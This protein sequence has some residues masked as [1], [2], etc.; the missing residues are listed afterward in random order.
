MIQHQN[1]PVGYQ[2]YPVN[3]LPQAQQFQQQFQQ[4]NQQTQQQQQTQQVQRT[5]LVVQSEDEVNRYPVAP[6]NTVTFIIDGKGRVIEKTLFSQFEEPRIKRF[7]MVEDD[8]P[9]V[10]DEPSPEY[11]LKSDL[12][13][14]EEEIAAIKDAMPKR[15]AKRK[16]TEDE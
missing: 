8:E 13:H 7:R 11:A 12:A 6:G 2:P 5:F 15:P 4:Y 10:V 16:E 3:A 1:F 14:I 9:D